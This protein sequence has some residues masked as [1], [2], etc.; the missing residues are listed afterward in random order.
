MN[1][2]VASMKLIHAGGHLND[3]GGRKTCFVFWSSPRSDVSDPRTKPSPVNHPIR[4]QETKNELLQNKEE[5]GNEGP[6]FGSQ[7]FAP[8]EDTDP[9][10]QTLSFQERRIWGLEVQKQ[11][12]VC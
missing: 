8:K 10:S 3:V 9:Q 6:H 4:Q 2:D 5:W 1:D 11:K 7:Y 12:E